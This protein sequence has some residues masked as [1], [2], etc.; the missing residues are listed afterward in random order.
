MGSIKH[1]S[2]EIKTKSDTLLRYFIL[3]EV[4]PGLLKSFKID[5]PEVSLKLAKEMRANF[6][7]FEHIEQIRDAY[8][9]EAEVF[10][11]LCGTECSIPYD[12]I[13]KILYKCVSENTFHRGWCYNTLIWQTMYQGKIE[14]TIPIFEEIDRNDLWETLPNEI[15]LRCISAYLYIKNVDLAK[16]YLYLFIK[17]YG[18]SGIEG[19]YPVA[20]LAQSCGF[21]S[22]R[23]M[24]SSAIFIEMQRNLESCYFENFIKDKSVA[25]VGNGPQE[26]GTKNGKKIDSYDV[27]IRFN[28]FKCCGFEDDYGSK[29]TILSQSMGTPVRNSEIFQCYLFIDDI[30]AFHMSDEI[31]DRLYDCLQNG[32]I[33]FAYPTKIIQKQKE[34]TGLKSLSSGL[35]MIYWVKSIN[36]HFSVDDCFGFSFKRDKITDGRDWKHYYKDDELDPN[37]IP[38][39]DLAKEQKVILQLFGGR[40]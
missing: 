16:K 33:I 4:C 27:V 30:Y 32:R 20:N 31:T 29:T 11:F 18:L 22:E 24:R 23:L 7:V 9:R 1:S 12:E 10:S 15:L 38:L 40:L 14:D 35:R 17:K 36:P 13:Q 2:Q 21:K 26:I 37:K 8:V 5:L 28:G 34:E 39:E 19:F 3:K 25:I 6:S